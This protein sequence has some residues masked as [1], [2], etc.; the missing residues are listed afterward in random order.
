M[1]AKFVDSLLVIVRQRV[2]QWTMM[3][4]HTRV[5]ATR[6]FSLDMSISEQS[7]AKDKVLKEGE[8]MGT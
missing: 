8:E 7:T 5:C 3:N 4:L 6:R 2:Q 1:I